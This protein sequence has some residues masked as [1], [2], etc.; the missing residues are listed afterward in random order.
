[1][2]RKKNYDELVNNITD[3]LGGVENISFF[4]HCATRLRFDIKDRGLV[5]LE[6]IQKISG[7]IGSQ[8]SGE[9]LQI[10]IGQNVADI[11]DMIAER[12]HLQKESVIA[13]NL[14]NKPKKKF[15]LSVILENIAGCLTPMIPIFVGA[16]MIKII[17]LVLTMLNVLTDQS[18][19]YIV[20]N[21]ASDAA[22][23]FFP[24][25]L[26][27]TSA[28]KFGGN[29]VLG[30]LLGAILISPVFIGNVDNK[31]PMSIFGLP[32]Y[33]A[34][35]KQTVF[36]T[37]LTVFVMSYVEKAFSKY[38]PQLLRSIIEPLGTL[39]VMI[40]LMLCA[41]APLGSVIG[42][43]F[44]AAI[45]WIYDTIGFVGVG[46]LSCLLPF[47]ILTGMHYGFMPYWIGSI[48]NLGYE[49]IYIL[50]N[51]IYNINQGVACLAVA[52]KTKDMDMKSVASSAGITSI[53]A[54]V[55][56]PALFGVTL[57]LKKP[58]WCSMIGC[59]IG[60]MIAGFCK[61]YVFAIPGTWG[62]LSLPIFIDKGNNLICMI[63]A[64]VVSSLI[65]FILTLLSFQSEKESKEVYN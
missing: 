10:I 8:W 54:G 38:S 12:N 19:T 61:V 36:P 59:A 18:P 30:M 13:E 21:F 60:G 53:V 33:A 11:Y 43:Y 42:T 51:V 62:I 48:M 29:P 4:S 24:V 49:P 45:M 63:I 31:V 9:Q 55:S 34:S 3:L 7:V 14:D 64:L 22:F 44:A 56:E 1:M 65:T 17:L 46:L 26:G 27:Y 47:L 6:D 2:S 15:S 39:L 37:I 25:F 40:P 16:G 32:I 5:K 50:S 52:L 41:L 57:Q 35:Y 28:K 58:L 20:L 23:Y